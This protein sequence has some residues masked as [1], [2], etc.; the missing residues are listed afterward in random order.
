MPYKHFTSDDRDA[1]QVLMSTGADCWMIARILEKHPSSIYRELSRNSNSG[2]YLSHHASFAAEKRRGVSRS[3]PKR[4]NA[5]LMIDIDQR[6]RED[7]SPEQIAG[8]LKLEHPQDPALH[9][10][11][12]TIY[13]HVYA[14]SRRGSDL[15][16]H[17]RQG[18]KKRRKR[19]SGKDRRGIIPNRTFIDE[20]PAIVEKKSRLGDWEGDTIEGGGKKGYI[21]TFVDRKSK[22]LVAFPLK[23]KTAAKLARGVRHAFAAIPAN[24][25]NTAT[26]VNGKSSHAIKQLRLRW[27]R[28]CSSLI[29]TTHGNAG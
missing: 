2:F 28:K 6:L 7:H 11:Y 22:F 3:S 27:E 17:L 10:S 12:E 19:L 14:E 26:V 16:T 9:I 21:G 5:A 24:G 23:H 1:L 4:G 15:G 20:R 13:K 29:H 18:H 8:R 25:K